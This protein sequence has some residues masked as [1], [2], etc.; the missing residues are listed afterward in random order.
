[1]FKIHHISN[2]VKSTDNIELKQAVVV[3][4][5]KVYNLVRKTDIKQRII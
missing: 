3:P 5:I 4:A 2:T 1:M